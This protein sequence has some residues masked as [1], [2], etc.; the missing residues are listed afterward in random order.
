[1]G[2]VGLRD[3]PEGGDTTRRGW[4]HVGGRQGKEPRSLMSRLGLF[5]YLHVVSHH[6]TDSLGE[7]N[8]SYYTLLSPAKLGSKR[9]RKNRQM[10][11]QWLFSAREHR[12][13]ACTRATPEITRRERDSVVGRVDRIYPGDRLPV[14]VI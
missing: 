7:V 2:Y 1:M 5:C 4:K 14:V 12:K 11:V 10:S 8:I 6:L 13:R 9:C 3:P